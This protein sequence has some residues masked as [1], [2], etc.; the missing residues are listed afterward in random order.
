MSTDYRP[1][2]EIAACDLFDGRLEEFGVRVHVKQDEETG[3]E[4]VRMLTDGCN[5][6]WV[7][8]D[9]DGFV[10]FTRY[11]PNGNPG[12]ILNAIAEIFDADIVSEYEPQYWGFETEEEWDAA[13][14]KRAEEHERE[15][16]IELLKY[17]RGEPNNIKPG[18]AGMAMADIAKKLGEKNP[19]LLL[20]ENKDKLRNEIDSSMVGDSSLTD[21]PQFRACDGQL[22]ARLPRFKEFWRD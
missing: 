17:C 11:M 2:K 16:Y 3:G 13:V 19:S 15:F 1:L 18:T 8:S 14:N 5:Y 10:F 7:Y 4:E 22:N 9:D 21:P 12:K 20:P 6:L